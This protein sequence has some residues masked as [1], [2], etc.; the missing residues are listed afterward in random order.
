MPETAAPVSGIVLAAGTSSRMGRNKLLLDVGGEPLVRRAVRTAVGAGLS[1][2]IVVLGHEAADVE[3]A[4]GDTTHRAVFN[5][6]YAESP[7]LSLQCGIRSVPE[8]CAGAVVLLGDMPFVTKEMLREISLKGREGAGVSLVVSRYGDVQAP[9][10]FY[11]SSLFEEISGLSSGCG[12]KVVERHLADAAVLSWPPE[13]LADLD[14]ADDY[15]RV[16]KRV[17][18]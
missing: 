11:S 8:E 18:G 14:V 9:P 15:D 7:R 5:E 3:K 2:V 1:P 6:R 4:I 17:A 12:K 16:K 10:T 13:L